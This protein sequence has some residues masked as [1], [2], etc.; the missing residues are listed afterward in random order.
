MQLAWL[1]VMPRRL[2]LRSQ[3]LLLFTSAAVV[4]VVVL[5]VVQ[6]SLVERQGTGVPGSFLSLLGLGVA[7]TLFMAVGF[8]F[9]L[10]ERVS[11]P[12]QQISLAMQGLVG[13][14]ADVRPPITS[15]LEIQLLV[16]SFTIMRQRIRAE[17]LANRELL[18]S[19]TAE[20]DKLALVIETIA[21]GV[22][23]YNLEGQVITANQAFYHVLQR[24]PEGSF[25]WATLQFY[26]VSNQPIP[27]LENVFSRAMTE[28]PLTEINRLEDDQGY[29]RILQITA[30]PLKAPQGAL[31]GGVAVIRDVT[32]QKESERLR[33]DF[34][35]TLTHDL[36]TPVL[37][38]VQTL[39]FT[40][41]GQ[42]GS[43]NAGQERIL[44]AV[45]QSHRE[46]LGLIECLLTIYRFEVGRMVLRPEVT[47]LVPL[48][49]QCCQELTPLA[50][51]RQIKLVQ[52]ALSPCPVPVDRQQFRRVVIN[53]LDNALKF[54]PSGG[55]VRVWVGG[56]AEGGEIRVQDNGRGIAP[57]R[58]ETLFARFQNGDAIAGTGLGLY[59]CRQV[60]EAHG[61]RIWVES[62]LGM[63]STFYLVVPR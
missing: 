9:W 14:N 24:S 18:T 33:E 17:T 54:T 23:V 41:D 59:L 15:V 6:W 57:E 60:V 34:V 1:V 50:Q 49:A 10:S 62:T 39:S 8:A 52:D 25:D 2:N 11:Q 22:L 27:L 47:D 53:L 40:L 3:Y 30:G 19:L 29:N 56:R 58:L 42:Y 5:G 43:L 44:T 4:P 13:D 16:D 7:I 12:L 55:E 63:G 32:A 31:L 26:D 35:A 21:E 61:G 37:A 45:V 48:V 38:A 36:R 51:T 20:K 46:L 28:G